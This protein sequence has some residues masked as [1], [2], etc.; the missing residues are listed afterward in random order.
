MQ[1]NPV[2]GQKLAENHLKQETEVA[3]VKLELAQE[4]KP[5][6]EAKAE[7]GIVQTKDDFDLA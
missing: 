7:N 2:A 5:D 3:A 4:T 1:M 6:A